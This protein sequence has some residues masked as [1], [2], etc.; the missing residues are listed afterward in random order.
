MR[1]NTSLAFVVLC[2]CTGF[3]AHAYDTDGPEVVAAG[4]LITARHRYRMGDNDTKSDASAICFLEA[5]RKAIEYA[6]TYV[7]SATMQVQTDVSRDARTDVRTIAASLVSAELVSSKTGFANDSMFIDCEVNA[8][9][10]R[11][12]LKENIDRIAADPVVFKQVE[13][14]QQRLRNLE[15]NVT[16]LQAELRNASRQDAI[17][18]RQERAVV[19]K[20]IDALMKKKQE[21]VSLIEKSGRDATRLIVKKMTRDEVKALL[22]EPRAVQEGNFNYG[23]HWVVFDKSS[24][25]ACVSDRQI[26][27]LKC[28]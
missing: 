16:K 27:H 3:P 2:L 7:E 24:L 26:H 8:R 18:L 5:K 22:G 14:Q 1:V 12:N 11:S 25:V 6:G 9:V 15:A 28:R 17:A 19:F 21:I 20:E 13:E 10:D 23:T 4:D